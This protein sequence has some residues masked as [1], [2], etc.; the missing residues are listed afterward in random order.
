MQIGGQD[1]KYKLGARAGGRGR[2]RGSGPGLWAKQ[3]AGGREIQR[4]SY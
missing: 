4:P 3:S 1:R 2:G